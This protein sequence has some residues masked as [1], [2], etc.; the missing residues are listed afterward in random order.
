[1]LN[2][3]QGVE[4]HGELFL[5]KPRLKP[6]IAGRADYRRFSEVYPTP[7]L[8]RCDHVWTYL[9]G[10]YRR[11]RTVGFKL[12][13]P[14]LR[15]YPELFVYFVSRRVRIV[16]LTRMNQLDVIISEERA[17]V[18]GVSHI[19]AGAKRESASVSLNAATLVDRIRRLN[20]KPNQAR[21]MLKW[22]KCQTLE[23][24]YEALLADT[25]EFARILSFL[26]IEDTSIELQSSLEK[27]GVLK[28]QEAVS[29][30]EEV[31]RVLERT[32]YGH[33]LRE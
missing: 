9:N 3:V 6:S 2:R 4:A 28:H 5:Q 19:Q 33:M 20:S 24:T 30:F 26:G 27:R 23:I 10:L 21:R 15:Q 17:R 18:S 22:G 13:Y 12:M 32:P 31:R 8:R 14:Q 29:N 7:G 16:H 25:Q 1:M 11:S